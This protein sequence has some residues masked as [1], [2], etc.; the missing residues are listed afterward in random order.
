MIS[1]A[2]RWLGILGGLAV[3]AAWSAAARADGP[4]YSYAGAGYAW[5][6][7]LYAVKQAGGQHE[8]A[9]LELSQGLIESGPVGIHLIAEYFDGDFTGVGPDRDSSGYHAG[10]GASYSWNDKVDLVGHAAYAATELDSVDDDGYLVEALLRGLV[11]Q[12][13]EVEAGVRYSEIKDSDNSNTD[14]SLAVNYSVSKAFA[15]RVRGV[16]LDNEVGIELGV[17]LNYGSLIGRDFLF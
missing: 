3:G 7:V 16:V 8:G 14:L 17:R 12:N 6:D 15:L 2:M 9:H 10:L 1:G 4:R 11:S 5:N 13:V